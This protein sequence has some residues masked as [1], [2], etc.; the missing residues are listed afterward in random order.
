MSKPLLPLSFSKKF[1]LL[2]IL[3]LCLSLLAPL[4][5][6]AVPG[7]IANH[8]AQAQIAEWVAQGYIK[9][10]PDGTFQPDK[11][12]SR[13]EFMALVNRVFSY[14]RKTGINFKDVPASAWFYNTVMEAKAAGYIS[15]YQ[16]GTM[17]PESPI[18]RAE[19]AAIIARIAA[20]D[21]DPGVIN[22]FKDAVNIPD[23]CKGVVGGAARAGLMGG[24]PDGT[25]QAAKLITRAET[26]AALSKAL[27]YA[28]AATTVYGRAGVYGPAEGTDTI[29]G[30]VAVKADGITLQNMVIEGN[31]TVDKAVGEGDVTLKNV[32]VL[33]TTYIKGGGANSIH[34]I[35]TVLKNTVVLKEG[36]I[37]R[38]VASG[39]AE[40][41]R[42][43]A[44]SG[45]KIEAAN[46][47]GKGFVQ[48]AVENK[49][50]G[51]LEVIIT[52]VKLETVEVKNQDVALKADKNTEIRTL[53][54]KA[55]NVQVA[56]EKGTTIT[57][58]VAGGKVSVTGQGTIE[59][60]EINASG[61][62][63]ETKPQSQE[64]ASGVTP[65]VT[66]STTSSG[67]TSSGG[68]SG[69][70]SSG[71]GSSS[72][73][74]VTVNVINN[75]NIFV[76]QTT[77]IN[78]T[79]N[80]ADA[81]VTAF[82]SDQ[83]V[84]TVSASGHTITVTASNKAG[85]ATVTVT[86]SKSGYNNGTRTF[87]VTV[88]PGKPTS[89]NLGSKKGSLYIDMSEFKDINN[90]DI[91]WEE[92][93]DIYG[94]DV[95]ASKIYL[96]N[97]EKTDLSVYATL[98]QLLNYKVTSIPDG[99]SELQLVLANGGTVIYFN[100][101]NLAQ[102]FIGSGLNGMFAGFD[103]VTHNTVYAEITG[104]FNGVNGVE[105]WVIKDNCDMPTFSTD[106]TLKTFKV[107]NENVLDLPGLNVNDPI[108]E[109]GAFLPLSGPTAGITVE[110]N[111][112]VARAVVTVNGTNVSSDQLATKQVNIY[113]V[114]IVTV[115]AESGN[116]AYY[117]V[118][119]TS[120]G[121]SGLTDAQKVAADKT[122]LTADVIKGGNP[123]LD[124][125]TVNLNLVTGIPGG[126]G[127]TISWASS[128]EGVVAANGTVTRPAAGSGD[129]TVTLT[130]TIASGS[131]SDTKQFTVTVKAQ[132]NI[133]AEGLVTDDYENNTNIDAAID[134]SGNIHLVYLKS[135]NVYYKK[136]SAGSGWGAEEL[137]AESVFQATIAVDSSGNP[138]IAYVSSSGAII[139]KTKVMG[140]WGFS[141]N[142]L[143]SG[144]QYVDL[145]VS[146]SETVHFAFE[147]NI[148]AD[149]SYME[150][151]YRKMS[152][153]TLT[154]IQVLFDGFYWYESGGKTGRYYSNPSIK[155]DGSDNYHV[156]VK[157]HALDGGMGWTDNNRYLIYKTNAGTGMEIGSESN[158]NS[159]MGISNNPIVLTSSGAAIVYNNSSGNMCIARPAGT[160]WNKSE[161]GT[162]G[163]SPSI[164]V[165]N[166]GN[167]II[168]YMAYGNLYYMEIGDTAEQ[169]DSGLVGGVG[170][171]VVLDAGTKAYVLYVKSDGADYEVYCTSVVR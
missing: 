110:T 85:S 141:Q 16:D 151:G 35:D 21:A 59:K 133:M 80:P 19:A 22:R 135:S 45:V 112:S 55:D 72:T 127:C 137:I 164:D 150:I 119:V 42:L 162:L 52:G 159:D 4:A 37:V 53:E 97:E 56:T 102:I 84:A 15:G 155:A 58:L 158:G 76:G 171:P 123:D 93:A 168:A 36:G 92:L 109:Q 61:V 23:W 24:Y 165:T 126:A 83:D 79:T 132:E 91:S 77:N 157:H 66:G 128:N 169:L 122:A 124:N 7:D 14:S 75:V 18:T 88:S 156:V 115:V 5:L 34:L 41:E 167:E 29:K 50:A 51:T 32:T 73:P 40:V 148:Y 113:D 70:G 10:Y 30:S 48:L 67:S 134:S 69:G 142:I 27:N 96:T 130:A 147:G 106:A 160:A 139:Y 95:S 81:T 82:S 26:V 129:A 68:S 63:F 39:K 131:A 111:D 152:G 1:V 103:P 145:D 57:T 12:I 149:D 62:T 104:S 65:P 20:L 17:K 99:I 144:G 2:L 86:A 105:T 71:G 153:G 89:F 154:D 8:W 25:F 116:Q 46:L 9:G 49:T 28:K 161:L 98:E 114:I 166:S 108:N 125:V 121:G 54:V 3:S 94:L 74:T 90:N 64:V 107:G 44:Q 163:S 11:N 170:F 31:L 101:T 120:S 6:G 118:T 60:A 87:T 78:V 146:P 47:E 117:K 13:A 33:G 138:H 38:L 43:T 136:Y 100:D 143:D 140:S